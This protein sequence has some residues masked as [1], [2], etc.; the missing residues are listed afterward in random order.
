MGSWIFLLWMTIITV[1]TQGKSLSKLPYTFDNLLI[2]LTRKGV[3][4]S[5]PRRSGAIS[6]S[7]EP[8]W[9]TKGAKGRLLK[10]LL[11]VLKQTLIFIWRPTPK[12]ELTSNYYIRGYFYHIRNLTLQR[13]PYEMK[14]NYCANLYFKKS[15]TLQ[16]FQFIFINF[17]HTS[18]QK[19]YSFNENLY[20]RVQA[21]L[22][23]YW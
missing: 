22:F 2:K 10:R 15:T 17:C 19:V 23:S 11:S 21:P 4:F 12:A 5:K 18:T 13:K 3:S 8:V 1:K 14:R 9:R 7:T 16:S 6:P 20:L